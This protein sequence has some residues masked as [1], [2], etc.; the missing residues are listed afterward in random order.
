MVRTDSL[1]GQAICRPQRTQEPLR[2]SSGQI[3]AR[4]QATRFGEDRGGGGG[5]DIGRQILGSAALARAWEEGD[6]ILAAS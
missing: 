4:H 5:K 6:S 1:A 2:C 3:K